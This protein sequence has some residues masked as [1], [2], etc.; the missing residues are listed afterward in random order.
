MPSAVETLWRLIPSWGRLDLRDAKKGWSISVLGDSYAFGIAG[1]GGTP[2]SAPIGKLSCRVL[3]IGSLEADM[4]C[5][6][7]I[8][9]FE[10]WHEL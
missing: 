7:R 8:G 2:S 1:T 4:V 5:D 9:P 6:M 10:L 3:S